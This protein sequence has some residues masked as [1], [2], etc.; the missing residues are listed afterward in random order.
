VPPTRCVACLNATI[1]AT[2]D[3]KR[4]NRAIARDFGTSEAAVRRHRTN[5]VAGHVPQ[6]EAPPSGRGGRPSKFTDDCVPRFVAA[7]PRR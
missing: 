2:R 4:S 6:G 3:L 7:H 1:D 5:H